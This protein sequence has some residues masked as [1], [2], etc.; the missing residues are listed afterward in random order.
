MGARLPQPG[1]CCGGCS[2]PE[3]CL[4]SVVAPWNV[5][6]STMVTEGEDPRTTWQTTRYR[7]FRAIAKGKTVLAEADIDCESRY[8]IDPDNGKEHLDT[9]GNVE[10]WGI[11]FNLGDGF[12]DFVSLV[13]TPLE[14]TYNYA[15]GFVT[16]VKLETPI[17]LAEQTA[18]AQ[19][20]LATIDIANDPLIT[21]QPLYHT[22]KKWRLRPPSKLGRPLSGA[23]GEVCRILLVPRGEVYPWDGT[24]QMT[25]DGQAYTGGCV[26]DLSGQTPGLP[27]V[28]QDPIAANG[29]MCQVSFGVGTVGWFILGHASDGPYIEITPGI[30]STLWRARTDSE[31]GAGWVLAVKTYWCLSHGLG[32]ARVGVD[33][34]HQAFDQ[35]TGIIAADTCAG[36]DAPPGGVVFTASGSEWVQAGNM[37]LGGPIAPCCT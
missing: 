31:G 21:G 29:M 28:P 26:V 14:L 22:V 1:C 37:P 4:A 32:C 5:F 18:R 19:A 3:Y 23:D 24:W 27:S 17:T 20:W 16:V 9:F 7:V 33:L 11:L 25:L 36:I 6:Y 10:E 8:T 13:Q 34:K 35:G 30:G 2:S 12:G 15:Q